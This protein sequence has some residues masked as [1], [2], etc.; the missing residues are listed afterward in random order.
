M[1]EKLM[2]LSELGFLLEYEDE[3]SVINWCNKNK[4]QV[5]N[6]GKCKYVI[7]TFIDMFFE[8]EI[9]GFVKK[10][11]ENSNEIIDAIKC[12]DSAKLSD[13]MSASI[14]NEVK[15]KYKLMTKESS[16]TSKDFLN[17]IKAA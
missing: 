16:K 13:L 12:N 10:H 2:K 8:N 17:N 14:D 7:S 15:K 6:F 1:K 5:I 3:R 9:S 4:I 11:Y